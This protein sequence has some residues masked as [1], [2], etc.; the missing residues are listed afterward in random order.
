MKK[1]IALLLAAAMLLTMTACGGSA[2][3]VKNTQTPTEAPTEAP[4]E[5]PAEAPTEPVEAEPTVLSWPSNDTY[6]MVL[7]GLG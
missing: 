3:P 7:R 2:E 4:T 5:E 1:L 6:T